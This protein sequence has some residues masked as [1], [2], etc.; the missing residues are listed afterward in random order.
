MSPEDAKDV[1]IAELEAKLAERDERIGQLMALV[2]ALT[3]RMVELEQKLA[4]NSSNSSRP[5]S[6]DAPGSARPGKKPTDLL[7]TNVSACALP[8]RRPLAMGVQAWKKGLARSRSRPRHDQD[9]ELMRSLAIS[10]PGAAVDPDQLCAERRPGHRSRN[11]CGA[12]PI[13]Q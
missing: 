5:P 8:K 1:R 2:G 6:S 3:Q 11:P 13:G 4:Q 7:Q 9:F 12:G 10:R